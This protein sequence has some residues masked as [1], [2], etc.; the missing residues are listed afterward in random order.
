MCCSLSAFKNVIISC[1]F[2]TCGSQVN[3]S[4]LCLYGSYFWQCIAFFDDNNVDLLGQTNIFCSP[5]IDDSN[6]MSCQS[7]PLSRLGLN[8]ACPIGPISLP[9]PPYHASPHSAFTL[10]NSSLKKKTG[11]TLPFCPL[12]PFSSFLK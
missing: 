5:F 9:S 2:K 8:V 1:F 3:H 7:N 11:F 12:S 6:L 10:F 4:K